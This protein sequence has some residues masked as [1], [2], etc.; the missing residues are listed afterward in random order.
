M[1]NTDTSLKWLNVIAF[2]RDLVEE[3]G[4]KIEPFYGLVKEIGNSDYAK[5]LFPS[6]SLATLYLT[7]SEGDST[8]MS[9]LKIEY[10]QEKQEFHFTYEIGFI[11]SKW[12]HRSVAANEGFEVL[13]RFLTKRARWFTKND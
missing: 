4:W 1:S 7:R 5:G 13:E 12:W 11:T 3:Y 8:K 6:T 9:R 2:Y 10:D